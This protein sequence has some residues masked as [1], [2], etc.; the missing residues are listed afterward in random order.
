MSTRVMAFLCVDALVFAGF[1]ALARPAE[2]AS[3]P[4]FVDVPATAVCVTSGSVSKEGG[5]LRVMERGMRGFVSGDHSNEAEL[6]FRY[7]GPARKTDALANGELR[8]QVGLKLRAKDTC[9]VVYVMWHF[10]PDQRVAVS[11]KY[12]PAMET[13]AECGAMGYLDK[14][15]KVAGTAPFVENGST[16]ALHARIDGSTLRVRA[17]GV[18]VWE[19]DLGEAAFAFDGPVGVR[20]DNVQAEMQLRI[21]HH[22]GAW[23]PCPLFR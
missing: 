13:H 18:L 10:S 22:N 4:P 23:K 15:P 9:N 1:L 16:H 7:I 8:M 11:V 14:K 21:P 3:A 20:T 12:N 19:G 2:S 5:H 6:V 17:D